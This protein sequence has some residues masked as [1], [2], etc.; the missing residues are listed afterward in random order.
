MKNYLFWL[1]I[2]ALLVVTV[3][4]A[5]CTERPNLTPTQCPPCPDTAQLN[6]LR[7]GCIVGFG[8]LVFVS[9]L[10]AVKWYFA[11]GG[12]IGAIFS[13]EEMLRNYEKQFSLIV[14]IAFGIGFVL[15]VI[16]FFVKNK[17]LFF[18]WYKKG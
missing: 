11:V 13:L 3:L 6:W 15:L 16:S 17:G 9:L 5:S 18:S 7:L 2:I 4:L 12:G 1:Y 10:N 8:V 14:F